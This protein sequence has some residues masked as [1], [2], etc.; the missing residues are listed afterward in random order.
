[1]NL[2]TS[3][4]CNKDFL[5]CARECFQQAADGRNPISMR[6]LAELGLEYVRIALGDVPVTRKASGDGSG[7]RFH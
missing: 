3:V 4:M 6:Q 7:F 2:E 5:E 1:V